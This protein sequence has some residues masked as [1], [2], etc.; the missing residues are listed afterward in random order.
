ME[1]YDLLVIG[2]GP[3]GCMAAGQAARRGLSVLLVERNR[4]PAR[5][6][7][8]TG[9]G[10]CNVTNNCEPQELIRQVKTNGRF[11]YAA[12]NR[13]TSQ[14]AMAFFESLGIPLKTERGNRVF[15]ESDRAMDIADGLIRYIRHPNLQ[16]TTGWRAKELLLEEGRAAGLVCEGEG[17]ERRVF[18]AASYLIATGGRSY[19]LTGSTGDGYLLARQAGHTH[20]AGQTL[21]DSYRAA[22]QLLYRAHG[23]F[24]QKCPA[25]CLGGEKRRSCGGKASRRRQKL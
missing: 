11:L 17:G 6:I 7:L 20:C 9:K 13:F 3:A 23:T 15:P 4:R 1:P 8:V 5:K 18:R 14:D 24:A 10:R 22:R 21:A 16:L 2:A 19:P 12:F 25:D